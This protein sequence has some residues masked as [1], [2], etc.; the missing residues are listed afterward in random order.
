MDYSIGYVGRSRRVSTKTGFDI[1]SIDGYE[2]FET[3]WTRTDISAD[4][5]FQWIK[6]WAR[7]YGLPPER[8][9]SHRGMSFTWFPGNLGVDD[10]LRQ[11]ARLLDTVVFL[12]EET[13]KLLVRE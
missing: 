12:E 5:V 4:F 6:I 8:R 2:Q 11:M 13:N 10:A 3:F 7:N 1:Y 9:Y